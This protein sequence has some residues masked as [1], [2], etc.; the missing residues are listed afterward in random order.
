MPRIQV[1]DN[2][3]WHELRHQHVGASEVAALFGLHPY[4]TNFELWHLK[5]GTIQPED[6][7]GNERVFWGTV[8]E[9]AVAEGIRQKNDWSVRK[10]HTYW[11][12]DK[13]AGMGASLDYEIV[14]HPNGPGVLQIKTTD[15][16]AFRNWDEGEPPMM[17]ELQLQHE[18]GVTNRQWGAL[19]VLVGG[20][21]L[22]IFERERHEAT[23]QR[24]ESAI[25]Q[26]WES[27]HAR[28]EPMPDYDE[29]LET[30][31]R[32]YAMAAP[33]KSIDL[34]TDNYAHDLCA[35]Y[36]QCTQ[37]AKE[38]NDRR[39]SIKAE[40]LTKIGDAERC[41]I[42][43]YT[44]SAKMVGEKDIAYTRR[45]YRDFRMNEKKPKKEAA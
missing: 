33:G 18:I 4:L 34:S 2:E 41:V 45:G 8:L 19:G 9:P 29:D 21:D 10:I 39:S 25:E 11:A 36:R 40:L 37:T 6:L 1:N 35:E 17:Y 15:S 5:A 14:D 3:H 13:V 42:G 20:N 27:V 38:A 23:I 22:R 16:L 44:I 12:H 28:K 31:A 7:S 43:P 24:I 26:F 30:I 32:L